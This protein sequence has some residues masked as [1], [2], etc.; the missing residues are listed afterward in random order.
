VPHAPI[1]V[2]GMIVYWNERSGVGSVSFDGSATRVPFGR[3]AID[4]AE[5][6]E[7]RAGRR[8][9]FVLDESA[10]AVKVARLQLGLKKAT[11]GLQIANRPRALFVESWT[12]ANDAL[13]RI[14]A[15]G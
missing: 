1:F 14:A 4:E 12:R 6:G 5:R 9:R 8:C 13:L 15:L 7:V 11:G 2:D 3:W 10:S